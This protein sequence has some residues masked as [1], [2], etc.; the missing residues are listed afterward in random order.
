MYCNNIQVQY[1]DPFICV[2]FRDQWL[3]DHWTKTRIMHRPS[4]C[5]PKKNTLHGTNI[6]HQTGKGNSS[7]KLPMV[8]DMLVPWK[9]HLTFKTK[10][11]TYMRSPDL[12][13]S[14]I[15]FPQV[16]FPIRLP[17]LDPFSEWSQVQLPRPMVGM[18]MMPCSTHHT[19]CPGVSKK[20][21][22][23]L[24]HLVV[25]VIDGRCCCKLSPPVGRVLSVFDWFWIL[26]NGRVFV[27]EM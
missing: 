14:T 26:P 2:W 11:D 22:G 21:G 1:L 10:K 19:W 5:L 9:I 25:F 18:V 24:R 13:A 12:S 16:F 27:A 6:S 23:S 4:I 7:S 20:M 3:T 15:F 17:K 8:R